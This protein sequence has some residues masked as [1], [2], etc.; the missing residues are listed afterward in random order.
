[1]PLFLGYSLTDPNVYNIYDDVV[2]HM[3]DDRPPSFMIVHPSEDRNVLRQAKLL[4]E[5][6]NICLIEAG[7]GDFLADLKK[8]LRSF[9]K[10]IER[11]EL[12][13]RHIYA[14]V[15]PLI[16]KATKNKRSPDSYLKK[17]KSDKGRA[18]GISAIVDLFDNPHIYE[19]MGGKLTTPKGKIEPEG[20]HHLI[21]C[22]IRLSNAKDDEFDSDVR[23]KI[24]NLVY[25][26]CKKNPYLYDFNHAGVVFRDLLSFHIRK[27]DPNYEERIDL[28]EELLDFGGPRPRI[29]RC[30]AIY[31]EFNNH[32]DWW[33]KG[34]LDGLVS[35]IEEDV[36]TGSTF[37][38]SKWWLEGIKSSKAANK[39]LKGRIDALMIES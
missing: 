32:K 19:K 36:K 3:G 8:G 22:I 34:E 33:K 4:F 5:R 28:L 31:D 11:Y 20:A 25:E 39:S 9:E 37:K 35:R 30:W 23:T 10:E 38:E 6:K 13:H 17:F 29:G 15:T 18:F 12:D 21:Q 2:A 14:R 7:I 24:G 26:H 16:E 27:G 1:V